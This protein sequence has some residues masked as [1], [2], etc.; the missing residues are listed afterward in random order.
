MLMFSPQARATDGDKIFDTAIKYTY[1]R[2]SNGPNRSKEID[3]WNKYCDVPL[4]SP[5]CSSFISYMFKESG[6]KGPRTAWSPA[7]VET[8]RVAFKDI[9]KGD[10][11]GLYFS[12][13]G[14]IAHVFIVEK[15]DGK[16][17]RTFEANTGKDAI[18]GSTTD[19]DGDGC[20]RRLRSVALMADSRNK[21]SRYWKK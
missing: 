12:S 19:R 21:Y 11:G 17:L 6:V 7:M 10:I 20:H 15:I 13:K 8:N 2:E 1:V 14:R 9:Q 4:G 16:Y 5:Y 18:I 3:A